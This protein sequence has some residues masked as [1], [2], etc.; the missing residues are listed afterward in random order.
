M[1]LAVAR[2]KISEGY[3]FPDNMARAAIIIGV[4]FPNVKDPK[5]VLKSEYYIPNGKEFQWQLDNTIRAVNQSL[6]RVIRHV[7]D[8]GSIFLLDERYGYYGYKSKISKWA[9]D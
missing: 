1:I 9:R 6:G 4:P 5:V 3:D 8:F 7:D 2:G